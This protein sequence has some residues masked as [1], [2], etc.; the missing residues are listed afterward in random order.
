M[1]LGFAYSVSH[2]QRPTCRHQK[3]N[4][5]DRGRQLRAGGHTAQQSASAV[6]TCRVRIFNGLCGLSAPHAGLSANPA[7]IIATVAPKIPRG[8]SRA[9]VL[10]I[11]CSYES[12]DAVWRLRR[13]RDAGLLRAGRT[14]SDLRAGVRGGVPSLVRVRLPARRV[15][16]RDRRSRLDGRRAPPLA[17]EVCRIPN[18]ESRPTSMITLAARLLLAGVFIVAGLAK[19][20]DGAGSRRSMADF[21]VPAALA[22]A[23]AVLVPVPELACA[24]ALVTVRLAWWGSI[25]A[26]AFLIAFTAG[27]TVNLLLGRKPDC[28]CFGQVHSSQIG[29][30]TVLRNAA[31]SRAGCAHRCTGARRQRAWRNGGME[32]GTRA[33]P[34]RPD[35]GA[36]PHRRVGTRGRLA[37]LEPAGNRPRR[38]ASGARARVRPQRPCRSQR[39]RRTSGGWGCRSTRRRPRLP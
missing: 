23:F 22:P 3:G 21:G 32:C 12:P 1:L 28:R 7:A 35:M 20:A 34:G 10:R 13:W 27:M 33:R 29:W 18:P 2:K 5:Q 15:A 26:S 16:I 37:V 36:G 38:S 11:H 6:P 17:C 9:D 14:I 24:A 4:G 31:A 25:G 39:G 19:L 30:P 8:P